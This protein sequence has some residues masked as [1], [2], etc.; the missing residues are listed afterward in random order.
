MF[1]HVT[2]S[3]IRIVHVRKNVTKAQGDPA[4]SIWTRNSHFHIAINT[5][6]FKFVSKNRVKHNTMFKDLEVKVSSFTCVFSK[7]FLHRSFS[8]NQLRRLKIISCVVNHTRL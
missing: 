2:K 1:N 5:S 7:S 6:P 4:L 3:N 8:E